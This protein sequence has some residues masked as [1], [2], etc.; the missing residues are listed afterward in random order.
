MKSKEEQLID[1]FW[2]IVEEKKYRSL[3][4]LKEKG[5][6]FNCTHSSF[7]GDTPLHKAVEWESLKLAKLFIK[8]GADVNCK[9]DDGYTPLDC[10]DERII[11]EKTKK[12]FLKILKK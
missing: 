9:N 4:T 2:E 3:K 1:F 5:F 10:L 12:K 7:F 6:D 11:C 8:Y